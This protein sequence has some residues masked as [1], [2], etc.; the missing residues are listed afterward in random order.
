MKTGSVWL[1]LVVLIFVHG[2]ARADFIA[3]ATLAGNGESPSTGTGNGEVLFSS[4]TDTLT[5]KLTFTGLES[6][7]I[8]P[9]GV[10]GAAHIHFGEIIP[11]GPI[12]F[13]FVEP[14][15]NNFPVGVTSGAY[16]TILTPASLL[17]DPADG[18]DTFAE[19]VSAIEA[20]KTYFNIHTAEFP[21][22]EIAGQ[23]EVI[24]EPSTWVMMFLGFGGLAFLG[25][26]QTRRAKPQA[27]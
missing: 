6:P 7:T 22:G 17:P 24:P 25:Y 20:G 27:A 9:P 13:P 1:A 18:I 11:G 23:I 8:I 15:A 2:S 26:R 5:I 16:E 14:N 3:T 19:A 21:G 10:P 4:T 12:I